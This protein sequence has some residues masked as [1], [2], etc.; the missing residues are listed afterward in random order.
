MVEMRQKA[1]S[2]ETHCSSIPVSTTVCP[3]SLNPL[4]SNVLYKMGQ[5]FSGH[6]VG[7]YWQISDCTACGAPRITK[8]SINDYSA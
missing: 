3:R 2:P 8:L 6:T 1:L 5:N 4:Y 7:S